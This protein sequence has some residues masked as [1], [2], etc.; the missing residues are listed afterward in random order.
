[1]KQ[2]SNEVCFLITFLLSNTWNVGW[3]NEITRDDENL[4]RRYSKHKPSVVQ[5][6]ELQ[7]HFVLVVVVLAFFFCTSF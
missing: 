7:K 3:F 5:R 4:T 1:M 6:S 2:I